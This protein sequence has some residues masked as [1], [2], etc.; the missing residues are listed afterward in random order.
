MKILL[1]TDSFLPHAGGSR[2]YYHNVYR[3]VATRSSDRVVVLTKK[4][5]GWKE[6]DAKEST[7]SFRI[8][9][10]FEPIPNYKPRQL[11]KGF[12]TLFEGLRLLA[13][14]RP[15]II[16]AGD[17]F[18][19]GLSALAIKKMLG[20]PYVVYCHG[21]EITQIDFRRHQP[22]VRNQIYRQADGIVAAS[23][24][25]QQNLLRIGI[26]PDRVRQITPGVDC[27]RFQPLPKNAELVRQYGLE[28][29]RVLLTVARLV[30]RK[31]HAIVLDAVAKLAPKMRDLRYLIVGEGPEREQLER[32]CGALGIAE[33][34]IFAGHTP[35]ELLVD[36]YNLCDAFIMI[37]RESRGDVE[38]FGMVFLEAN[39]A[40]RPVIGG[41]SGGAAQ[42]VV[43]GVTG[44]LV[45]PDSPEEA[46]AAIEQLMKDEA[47]R[48]RMSE[49][50]LRRARQEFSWDSRSD[51]LREFNLEVLDRVKS[52]KRA[53]HTVKSAAA[54]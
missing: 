11:P 2:V 1:I 19:P 53:R 16:H 43:Q 48:R 30:K 25:A 20:V 24:F 41:H 18:P 23:S 34:V 28:G 44:L 54:I 47:M 26:S 14:E 31:G 6:F 5:P 45:N 17:L 51:A 33:N 35:D 49:T 13:T 12:L 8:V 22:K 3:R 36:F 32:Q 50:G 37:N 46:A 52:E 27:E 38:G 42:A 29:K 9:R 15:D 39:A 21:E 10:R 40:G 4:V 7:P